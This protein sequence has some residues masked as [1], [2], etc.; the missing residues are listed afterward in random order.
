V[1][2]AYRT[3]HSTE[4]A[5]LKVSNDLLVSADEKDVATFVAFLDQSAV[6]DLVDH[7]IDY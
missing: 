3:F 5:L 2:S 6:F 7:Q 1:Q 4:T